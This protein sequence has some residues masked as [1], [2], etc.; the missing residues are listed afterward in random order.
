MRTRVRLDPDVAL[1]LTQLTRER[2]L[3]FKEALN[4][5]LRA[6]LR[7]DS[8]TEIAFPVFDM[9]EPRVDLTHANRLAVV[10]EDAVAARTHAAGR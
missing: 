4:T 1:R 10:L 9:G 7:M 3:T 2:G 5:T 8:K 6:G